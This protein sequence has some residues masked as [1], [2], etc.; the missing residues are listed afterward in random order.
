MKKDYKRMFFSIPFSLASQLKEN[1]KL[2]KITQQE[3]FEK[4]LMVWYENK[5]NNKKEIVNLKQ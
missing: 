5:L 1:A 4:I 2:K 3:L